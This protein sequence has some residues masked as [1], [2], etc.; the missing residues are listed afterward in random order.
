VR[1]LPVLYSLYV[2][3]WE[4]AQLSAKSLCLIPRVSTGLADGPLFNILFTDNFNHKIYDPYNTS[5]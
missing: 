5:S 3:K 1:P 4:K 2:R